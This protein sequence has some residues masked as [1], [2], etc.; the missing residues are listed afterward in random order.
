MGLAIG[1]HLPPQDVESVVMIIIIKICLAGRQLPVSL[2]PGIVVHLA[3]FFMSHE[4]QRAIG[5][6]LTAIPISQVIT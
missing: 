4:L 3:E 5:F 2:M 6:N 1:P